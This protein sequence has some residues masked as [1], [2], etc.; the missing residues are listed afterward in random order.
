MSSARVV[1]KP[2]S[3]VEPRLALADLRQFVEHEVAL[4]DKQR[5]EEWLNLFS[6]DGAYWVRPLHA[7]CAGEERWPGD[8]AQARRPD[9]LRSEL[10]CPDATLL[11]WVARP[12]GDAGLHE[13]RMA[14]SP[15]SAGPGAARAPK[16]NCVAPGA[17][18]TWLLQTISK[19]MIETIRAAIRKGRLAKI[20]DIVPAYVF[21]A[22]DEA[23]HFVGQCLSP[24][25][26]D[27]ML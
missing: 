24:N 18:E 14:A 2:E 4:L 15:W 7:R 20:D 1:I 23:R 25:G 12:A 8:R 21:L 26:G 16:A 5:F 11:G 9:E 27:V 6:D 3:L 19:E 10:P 22:S 13:D 17:T